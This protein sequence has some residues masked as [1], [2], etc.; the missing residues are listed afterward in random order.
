MQVGDGVQQVRERGLGRD[1]LCARSMRAMY[2]ASEYC[3]GFL[4]ASQIFAKH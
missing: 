1:A 4:R 3:T 2:V